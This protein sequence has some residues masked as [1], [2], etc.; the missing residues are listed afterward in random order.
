MA[1]INNVGQLVEHPSYSS[2]LAPSDFR[3]FLKLKEHIY[4]KRFSRDEEVVDALTTSY[5]AF[6]S[7]GHSDE[8]I[9]VH[10]HKSVEKFFLVQS[11]RL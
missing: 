2:D 11:V 9:F 3:L 8:P 1:A 4:G 7:L 6:L 10:G 5:S